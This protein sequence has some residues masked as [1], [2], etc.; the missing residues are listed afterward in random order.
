MDGRVS[1]NPYPPIQ[2]VKGIPITK[3]L[4]I[5]TTA[6]K[7]NPNAIETDRKVAPLFRELFRVRTIALYRRSVFRSRIKIM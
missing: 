7:V 5:M 2:Y 3:T 6:N 4:H 1:R